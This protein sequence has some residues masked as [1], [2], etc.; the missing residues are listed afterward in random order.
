ML[1]I[2]FF[3]FAEGILISAQTIKAKHC[4]NQPL[5][6]IE[7]RGNFGLDAG[8]TA[9]RPPP[10]LINIYYDPFANEMKAA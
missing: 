5:K 4:A 8:L 9:K 1:F 3:E 10:P 2:V 6:I 7:I